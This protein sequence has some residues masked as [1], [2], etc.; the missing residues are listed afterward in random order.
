[1][2]KIDTTLRRW[3]DT[4]MR[5]TVSWLD[6]YQTERC[7]SCD[8]ESAERPGHGVHDRGRDLW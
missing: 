6:S 5:V 7:T 3:C 8:P 4:C 1:M 2:A